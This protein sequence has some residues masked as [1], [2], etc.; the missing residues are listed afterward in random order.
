MIALCFNLNVFEGE[1]I[2]VI[3]KNIRMT[4]ETKIYLFLKGE[5]S[6]TR[7]ISMVCFLLLLLTAF[8]MPAYAGELLGQTNF[9]DGIGLPWHTVESTPAKTTFEIKDGKY[10]ITIVNPGERRWDC[11]FRHRAIKIQSGHTY[12]VKYTIMASKDAS[13]YAK[14]GDQKDPYTEDWH[15]G[16]WDVKLIKAN[17]PITVTDTFTAER[18]A[19]VCEFAFQIGGKDV[20]AGTVWT[21]DDISFSD[22]EAITP[23]PYPSPTP[24]GILLNQLGYYPG[25]AKEATLVSDSTSPVK[26]EL[27]DSSGTVVKTGTTQP[28]GNDEDSGD[29]VHLIDFSDYKT[30]GKGYTLVAGSAESHPFDIGTDIY[31]NMMYDSLKYF[32]HCR[33]G[34]PIEPKYT[35]PKVGE[36][37]I[38][39]ARPAGHNPDIVPTSIYNSGSWAYNH[40]HELDITGGW[41]DSGDYS[42]YV[43]NGGISVWTMQN[44]YERTLHIGGSSSVP[45]AD[46]TMNIPE[47]GN[48]YPDILDEAR[49]HMEVMLKMQIPSG[50]PLA[51]MVHHKTHNEVWIGLALAPHNDESKRV[52]EPP[53]TAATLNLAATAAQSY[54]LWKSLDSTYAKKCIDAA[55]IAWDAAVENP[56]R[57]APIDESIGGCSYAEE[58]EDDDFY[59]AACELYAATGDSKYYDYIKSSEYFL[60][61]PIILS[62]GT[63][64]DSPSSFNWG[65]THSMGTLTLA[66]VDCGLTAEEKRTAKDNIIKAADYFIELE[67]GQGYGIPFR[68]CETFNGVSDGYPWGSNSY[69]MN[70]CIITAYAYDH[71]QDI[72]YLNGVTKGMDY[73]MG[74]NPLD[75]VYVTGYGD[76]SVKYPYHT[77]FAYQVDPNYPMAPPGIAVGG[78][79]SKPQDPWAIGSGLKPGETAPQKC[80]IDH[81][82]SWSTNEC[83]IS[84]NASMAWLTG[85][86]S[87]VGPRTREFSIL[88]G[89]IT[90]DGNVNAVD[91]ATMRKALLGQIKL[92]EKALKVADVN[93]SGS[94]DAIDFALMR[95]LLLGIITSFE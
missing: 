6:M 69:V 17:T 57:F 18:N 70:N 87:E 54:R 79:N 1:K 58:Y 76:H 71:S 93:K 51:G 43:V 48:K 27:K 83:S 11:Q 56:G 5:K 53:T 32:Y 61:V 52:L 34:V 10:I 16:S 4:Y 78:P 40:Y 50:M 66:L 19:N 77:Y 29:S 90:L 49:I 65:N 81:I 89:D 92:D 20:Q 9:D 94:F 55:E 68:K 2:K 72:K 46:G 26:W 7:K 59:W 35:V 15:G 25:T 23:T 64:I 13:Y 67:E 73:L 38:K 44:Q 86:L 28:K 22:P 24:P 33:S 85:Y 47:S 36:N 95:K 42:K 91:F 31:D 12:T 8:Q 21:F 74:R 80:Y 60:K 37:N 84:W 62:Q 75:Y 45:Y 88:S 39:W 3:I 30:K 82:E 63:E 41:Y 14:I